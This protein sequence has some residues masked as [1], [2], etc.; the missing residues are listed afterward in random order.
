MRLSFSR[1]QRP[2]T[3]YV[4]KSF[5]D[6]TGKSTSRRVETLGSEEE[7]EAKYGCP[8]G[9]E[10]AKAYVAKLNEEE[11]LGRKKVCIELSPDKPIN[12]DAQNLISGGDIFLLPL[13]NSLGLPQMC[14][15]I[16]NG[17]KIKYNLD[18]ILQAMVVLRVLYPCSK[19]SVLDLNQKRISRSD[20]AL[21]NLYR[22]LTLLS[23]HIDSIQ[24]SVWENS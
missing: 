20:I 12:S 19:R 16:T 2:H 8:D 4:R 13:Y 23:M 11:K 9:L 24:A 7:I 21:E 5:R 6:K 3:I 15:E 14:K 1:Q 18:E 10:W 22:A 17:S